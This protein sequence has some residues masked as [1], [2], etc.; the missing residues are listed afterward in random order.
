MARRRNRPE[1]SRIAKKRRR[2]LLVEWLEPRWLLSGTPGPF[3]AQDAP[4]WQ[5]TALPGEEAVHAPES[6]DH[7]GESRVVA[8]GDV[9]QTT[10]SP[11]GYVAVTQPDGG[12]V[13][14]AEEEFTIRWESPSTA[15][16]AYRDAVLADNPVGYWRLGESAA[17][18]PAADETG[19]ARRQLSR[20]ARCGP[21]RHLYE[22]LRRPLRRGG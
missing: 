3:D 5:P 18:D 15:T 9:L 16:A 21:T 10:N 19:N 1:S 14:P 20:R 4:N 13:W 7:S 2:R 22:R 6:T 11:T 12:E 17:T 8:Y